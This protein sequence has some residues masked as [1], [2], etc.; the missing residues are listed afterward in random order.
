MAA[1]FGLNR[2]A[3][4]ERLKKAVFVYRTRKKELA[5]YPN[6]VNT[7]LLSKNLKYENLLSVA[8]II[9]LFN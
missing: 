7:F 2:P 9:N 4:I 1:S 5:V 8:L 3:N 6:K